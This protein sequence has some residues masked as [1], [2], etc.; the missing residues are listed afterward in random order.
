YDVIVTDCTNIQYRSNGD[1]YTV[2]YFRLMKDR[3]TANGIAAA[4]VPANGIG[5]RDLKTLIR[6]FREVFPHTSLWYMDSLPTDFLIVVGSPAPL[7]VDFN[8]LKQRMSESAVA[9]DLAEVGYTDPYRLLHTL[10]VSEDSMAAYLE[11]GPLNTDDRPVLSYSSYG[12]TFKS[13]IAANLSRLLAY[14]TE[15]ARHVGR[16][17]S[18]ALLLR[19]YAASN[20]LILGHIA[21]FAGA[22]E[23]ALSHYA[24]AARLLPEDM[25]IQ[26]LARF[27]YGAAR[28]P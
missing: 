1:L 10:L 2:D 24:R 16:V 26:Q 17:A 25:A 11:S 13:T 22:E 4:W 5:D 8:L 6:S 12:A 9:A 21:H 14:R 3:L 7:H 28:H 18:E 23:A 27:A 15:P 20:E 19:H